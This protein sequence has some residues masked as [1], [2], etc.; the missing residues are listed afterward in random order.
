MFRTT[1]LIATLRNPVSIALWVEAVV[2]MFL[3]AAFIARW[4]IGRWGWKSFIA[5]SLLG[6]LAFSVPAVVLLNAEKPAH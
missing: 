5:L 6:G 3:L 4:P 2:V 1:D